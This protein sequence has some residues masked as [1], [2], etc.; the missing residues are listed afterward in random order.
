M[1]ASLPRLEEALAPK[2]IQGVVSSRQD[3][4]VA[5]RPIVPAHS[6]QQRSGTCQESDADAEL[7]LFVIWSA[8]RTEEK[9]IL[10]DIRDHLEVR[11]VH[12]VHWSPELVRQNYSRFYRGRLVPPYRN[13]RL[14]KGSGP[15]LVV[16]A[17]DRSPRYEMRETLHGAAVVNTTLFDAKVRHRAW[18]GPG[19]LVHGSDTAAEAERD[20]MLLLGCNSRDY[21][22]QHPGAWDGVIRSVRRDLS[23]ARGW[24]SAA[25]LFGALNCS[26]DY[27]VLR[28]ADALRDLAGQRTGEVELLTNNYIELIAV[29]NARPL[30]RQIPRRGGQFLIRIADRDRAF[31]LR[32]VGDRYFDPKWQRAVLDRRE[33][34]AQGFFAPAAND[35]LES[36]AYHALVHRRSLSELH[37]ARL[38]CMAR[39]LARPEWTRAVL[40][41]PRRMKALLDRGLAENGY[42]YVRPLDSQVFYN[43]HTVGARW[44]DARQTLALLWGSWVRR[45][46]L[47][48]AEGRAHYFTARDLL[49]RA[50]PWARTLL[51]RGK[52]PRSGFQAPTSPDPAKA[53]AV[54]PA[55]A[56]DLK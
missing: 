34:S 39:A 20:L 4:A 12:E 31:A 5:C 38:G 35:A 8:A 40:D 2:V 37:K 55:P 49:A 14:N 53:G 23:G 51:R 13:V 32:F 6:L 3:R 52:R 44:P 33:V 24:D 30:L 10:A 21:L 11:G 50:A 46:H 42:S 36:L 16:T 29:T 27:V 28:G 47:W 43:F 17:L 1:T 19:H 45:Y 41:D 22:D 25:Q 18:T 48:S 26:V 7:H 56:G 9:R 54:A 15:L